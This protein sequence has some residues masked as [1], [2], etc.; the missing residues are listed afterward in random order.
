MSPISRAHIS[1]LV[2][3]EAGQAP[4]PRVEGMVPAV[5]RYIGLEAGQC[6]RGR[7][8]RQG[9]DQGGGIPGGV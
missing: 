5:R 9:Q 7:Y 2:E 3:I 6:Q 1:S 4:S 8:L